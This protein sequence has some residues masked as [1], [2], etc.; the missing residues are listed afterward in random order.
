[1]KIRA[2]FRIIKILFKGYSVFREMNLPPKKRQA[3][4]NKRFLKQVKT[5]AFQTA[6]YPSHFERNKV[7]IED[8]QSI[9]D[10]AKLPITTKNDLRNNAEGVTC[11]ALNRNNAITMATS[12]STGVPTTVYRDDSWISGFIGSLIFCKRMHK[13]NSVKI[14]LILDVSTQNSI[15]SKM[16]TFGKYLAKRLFILDMNREISD[17][18]DELEKSDINY[19][20]TYTGVMRELANLRLAGRGQNLK[21]KKIFLSGEI[22]D[23][24]TRELVEK[25]FDCK[26]YSVYISTEGGFIAAECEQKQMHV[27]SNSVHVEIVDNDGKPVNYGEIGTITLTGLDNGFGSKIIRYAGCADAG[28]L[29]NVQCSCGLQTPILGTI[30]G[31]KID[32]IHLRNG[33]IFHPFT[34]TGLM[35]KIQREYANDRIR[36]YQIV[37]ES[38]DLI[39]IN[40]VRNTQFVKTHENLED[41]VS[42]IRNKYQF[43][44]NNAIEFDVN[45]VVSIPKGNNIGMPT[46]LVISKLQLNGA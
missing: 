29:I 9:N 10:I 39:T 44:V 16:I 31:R 8:I 15:E 46:P 2:L 26:C 21:F 43:W 20:I 6:F 42:L 18:M 36:Q 4:C 28:S 33:Q 11:K 41:L 3:S 32:T 17:M 37:Q 22:L 25:A 38:L 12:G 13:I 30:L 27:F 1:M 7:N 14:G 24:Y 19:M 45:E 35:E 23:N 34:M 5:R 40:L